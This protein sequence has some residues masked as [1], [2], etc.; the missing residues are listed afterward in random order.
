MAEV[1]AIAA[2]ALQAQI[3]APVVAALAAQATVAA[4]VAQVAVKLP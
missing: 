4:P 3:T 1:A 2:E